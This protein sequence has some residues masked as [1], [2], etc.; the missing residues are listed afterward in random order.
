MRRAFTLIELLVVIAIIAI[1]AAMLLPALA[2][3]KETAKKANC[4]NNLHQL[5]IGFAMYVDDN[6][7]Y[8][9]RATS[10]T[11]NETMWWR[12]VIPNIGGGNTNDLSRAKLLIC[13]SYPDKTEA[14]CYAVN[15]WHFASKT[16][17]VGYE[18]AQPTKVSQFQK[19][20][21]SIYLVDYENYPGIA[22]IKDVY[23]A[24]L[25]QNDIWTLSHLPYNPN[26]TP[27]T[28]V[29]RVASARH[30]GNGDDILFLDAH[31]AFKKARLINIDDFRDQKP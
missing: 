5:G 2:R 1:L 23:S 26:G 12:L 22:I 27:N 19:P 4:I 9:P 29:N 21:D 7:G 17:M 24:T 16:D 20:V 31:V 3:A 13:P 6:R 30:I 10:G 28:G 8:I 11:V 18:E 15:G 25:D 14:V